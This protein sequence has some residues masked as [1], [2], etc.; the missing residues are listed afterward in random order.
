[1]ALNTIRKYIITLKKD[2][3]NVEAGYGIKHYIKICYRLKK[4]NF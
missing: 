3:F 1:M 4:S 2:N